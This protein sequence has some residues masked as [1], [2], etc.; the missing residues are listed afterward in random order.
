MIQSR[1]MNIVKTMHTNVQNLAIKDKTLE[2]KVDAE[3]KKL[4]DTYI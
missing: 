1:R 4:L 3:K 2:D